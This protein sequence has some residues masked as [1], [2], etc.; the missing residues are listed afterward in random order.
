MRL[1]CACA[2]SLPARRPYLF[3]G[4][5]TGGSNLASGWQDTGK[6]LMGFSAVAAVAIPTILYHAAKITAGALLMELLAM[7]ILGGTVLA[8]QVLSE[9][10]GSSPF[11]Y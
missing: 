5:G 7:C 10:E 11:V 3:F 6:F 4:G 9:A 2:P 1:N 8:W